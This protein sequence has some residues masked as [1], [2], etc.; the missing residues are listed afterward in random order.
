MSHLPLTEDKFH[1]LLYVKGE[2]NSTPGY[3]LFHRDDTDHLKETIKEW[4][5]MVYTTN[6][7][8][9]WYSLTKIESEAN[10]V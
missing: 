1:T 3:R 5:R 8:L 6:R 2:W 9:G 7:W 10:L 4:D